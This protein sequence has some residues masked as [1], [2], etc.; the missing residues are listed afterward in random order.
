MTNRLTINQLYHKCSPDELGCSSS[1]YALQLDTIIG[2]ERAV[3]SLQ[4]GLGIKEKG[5]NI[6]IAGVHGTGRTTAIERYLIDF[7]AGKP[8]P[9]DWCYV[10]NFN[11]P[12]EPNALKMPSG[13]AVSF[14]ED[15]DRTVDAAIDDLQA[16]FKSEE[17][18]THKTEL[19]N[20]YQQQKQDIFTEI[21][22][23]AQ[24]EGFIL[25][26]TPMGLLTV[27][28][29]AE[30]PIS[31]QEFIQLKQEEKDEITRKQKNLK[32]TLEEATRKAQNLDIEL[33]EKIG[34]LNKEVARFAIKHHFDVLKEK[35]KNFE[36][37]PEHIEHVRE[38]ILQNTDD[39][40]KVDE[41]KS[42]MPLMRRSTKQSTLEKY[43][44]NILVD[45]SKLEGAPVIV[46][47]NPT[48]QNIV[49]KV[50]H[51][52]AFGALVTNFDL[53]HPGCLHRANGGFLVLPVE[54]LLRNP[55]GWEVLKRALANQEIVIEEIGER[56]GFSTKSLRPEPIP[57][58]V[59]II[60]IGEP[61]IFHLL[62]QFDK[63][64]DELFKVKADFDTQMPRTKENIDAY[65]SF[66][67]TLCN[68]ENLK[69][70]DQSALCRIIEHA[71]RMADDQEKLSTRFG[72]MSDVIR[73]AN[74]YAASVNSENINKTHINQAIEERFYR[75]SLI[76]DRL[77]ELIA[78]ERIKIEVTGDKVGELNG[79]SV[80]NLGDIIFGQPSRISASIGLG[81]D[82]VINIER[83]AEMS[84][85]IHTK[86]VL[87]LS[88]YLIDN[89]T[90]DKPLSLSARLV[91][92][93]NYTGVEGDSASSTELYALLS[94]L[95]ELP[96]K[97]G[98]A[99]TGS[100]NQKGEIQVIGGVNEKIEGYFEVCNTRGLT[101]N[102]GVLI[103]WGNI[104]DLMLKE[105][106]LNAVGEDKFHIWAVKSVEEGIEILTGVK[107]G[108]RQKDGKYEPDTVFS[109][110]DEK[111][112]NYAD[113]L[114]KFQKESN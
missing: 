61:S 65:T 19:V 15:M 24:S 72:E 37:L 45:N 94:A 36:E 17:Y 77:Q 12:G 9:S 99:V 108:K 25:Q 110:A 73:E 33:R 82:G 100:I 79:L 109:R 10:F 89:F 63:Q 31:D 38:D 35:Y 18:T 103:P 112:S 49:G 88:G 8:V 98:I 50:E 41:E 13:K 2:Q 78:R 27:P 97:Q 55:F 7:A 87:I 4:F 23:H 75:S 39:I 60:L 59:K 86:G 81:H 83:E 57:L 47:M 96:I 91:F 44:V 54:D 85:P 90:Q 92:E 67:C 5:F 105:P 104:K 56:Y 29:R 84:G 68:S 66:V 70:L 74:Y 16:A 48:F 107:A 53:I 93:Q 52:L 43:T 14:K 95:S 58:D 26:P 64:F 76:R 32:S 102:Q 40:I 62:L 34:N 11:N 42:A 21:G 30:R 113:R 20:R 111:L 69:H 71:S 6:Y 51:E 101:G 22:Q 114:V 106:V 3:R 46:E 1:E 80:L 28:T